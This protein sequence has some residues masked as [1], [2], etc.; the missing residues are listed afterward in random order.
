MKKILIILLSFVLV[1]CF[2]FAKEK[3]LEKK[4]YPKW[5]EYL[6]NPPK[7]YEGIKFGDKEVLDKII[8]NEK[9]FY[10]YSHDDEKNYICKFDKKGNPE[11][12]EAYITENNK[13]VYRAEFYDEFPFRP[14]YKNFYSYDEEGK[15]ENYSEYFLRN[16]EDNQILKI[17]DKNK[18]TFVY[19]YNY[20]GSYSRTCT[21]VG[22]NHDGNIYNHIGSICYYDKDGKWLSCFTNDEN[23]ESRYFSGSEEFKA[24][25]KNYEIKLPEENDD[26]CIIYET[27]KNGCES[28]FWIDY[29]KD[30]WDK[31]NYLINILYGNVFYWYD[32]EGRITHGKNSN[33]EWWNTFQDG[34]LIYQKRSTGDIY[35]D[36]DEKGNIILEKRKYDDKWYID[37]YKY[38]DRNR[39]VY[40][41]VK[42]VDIE[43]K[44]I[45]SV[46]QE[47]QYDNDDFVTYAKW[48][49]NGDVEGITWYSKING[50]EFMNIK[51]SM[52]YKFE[53]INDS[54]I[55]IIPQDGKHW[56]I[57]EID[58]EK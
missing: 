26:I 37:E 10:V 12:Y 58:K 3:I 2:S 57:G 31:E 56:F 8:K 35:F 25:V 19:K 14:K 1:T 34:K 44:V 39:L 18:G 53:K 36:Y 33:G 29:S 52:E 20:D 50:Y 4:D 43:D 47:L 21:Q 42:E 46:K 55:K 38:D 11:M 16:D 40:S 27:Y 7:N 17:S 13:I 41:Y 48:E 23:G 24:F 15:L 9:D 49:T 30:G 28:L 22:V 32:E 54:Q 5:V 51:G 6:T 45:S